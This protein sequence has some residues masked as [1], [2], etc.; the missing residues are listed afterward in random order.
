MTWYK[1]ALCT[2]RCCQFVW[3]MGM[4]LF[5]T[6]WYNYLGISLVYFK[7]IS[8]SM[9][10]FFNCQTKL[11]KLK[12]ENLIYFFFSNCVLSF[13]WCWKI[14]FFQFSFFLKV[15]LWPFFKVDKIE[16]VIYLFF[17]LWDCFYFLFILFFCKT[18]SMDN[19]FFSVLEK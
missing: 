13:Y 7:D 5:F 2:Y 12:K 8:S 18:F 14:L 10:F 4:F 17:H 11:R 9:I 16:N 19:F 6:I 15:F 1:M 3:S